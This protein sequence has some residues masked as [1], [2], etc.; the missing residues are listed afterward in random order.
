MACPE[1][2][3]QDGRGCREANK[4]DFK[5]PGAGSSVSG[6]KSRSHDVMIPYCAAWG[7]GTIE[8]IGWGTHAEEKKQRGGSF[9]SRK[10]AGGRM[11]DRNQVMA[12]CESMGMVTCPNGG[13]AASLAECGPIRNQPRRNVGMS[14]YGRGG[15]TRPQPRGGRRRRR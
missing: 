14:S 2:M 6:L 4:H 1:G 13:C 15:R 10:A 9:T 3:I 12:P 8:C 7:Q 5:G 11:M